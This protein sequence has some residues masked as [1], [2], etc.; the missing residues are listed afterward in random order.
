MPG[1]PILAG[2]LA[3]FIRYTESVNA[4]GVDELIY[5]A[6]YMSSKQNC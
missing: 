6:L 3:N 2:Y 1:F 4:L 5:S